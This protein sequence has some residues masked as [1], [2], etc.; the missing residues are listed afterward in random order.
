MDLAGCLRAMTALASL[1]EAVIRVGS[2]LSHWPDKK[3]GSSSIWRN[4]GSQEI[5][6]NQAIVS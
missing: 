5:R 3:G 4:M 6:G 2:C 1:W